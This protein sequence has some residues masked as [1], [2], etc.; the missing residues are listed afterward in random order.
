MSSAPAGLVLSCGAAVAAAYL[1]RF[2][3]FG[4]VHDG[5]YFGSEFDFSVSC[6]CRWRVVPY[7]ERWVRGRKGE[8]EEGAHQTSEGRARHAMHEAIDQQ[9]QGETPRDASSVQVACTRF[10]S[11]VHGWSVLESHLSLELD[12]RR[13]EFGLQVGG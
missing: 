12:E 8:R 11:L 13:L 3:L 7:A 4:V 5:V 9:L 10:T 2:L 6:G 1:C